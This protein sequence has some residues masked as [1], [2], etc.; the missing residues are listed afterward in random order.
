MMILKGDDLAWEAEVEVEVE[1]QATLSP[2][3]FITLETAS[4][5]WISEG[6]RMLMLQQK[7]IIG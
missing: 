3:P 5:P 1:V 2:S 7:M 6:R 4:T